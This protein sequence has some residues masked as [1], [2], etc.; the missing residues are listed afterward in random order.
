M[1]TVYD[2]IKGVTAFLVL[3][4]GKCL[5]VYAPLNAVKIPVYTGRA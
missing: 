2:H 3:L 5:T 1:F 4:M